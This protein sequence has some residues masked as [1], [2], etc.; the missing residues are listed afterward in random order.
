MNNNENSIE[1][2]AELVK[3]IDFAMMT[4][5]DESGH[6]HSRP[7]S[8]QQ[9]DKETSCFW[10]FTKD[11]FPKA[12]EIDA[13]PHVNLSYSD[14]AHNRY[15]SV[16]GHAEIIHDKNKMKELWNPLLRAWFPLGLEEPHIC[17]IR[18]PVEKAEYWD[19]PSSKMIQLAGFIKAVL[20]GKP[21]EYAGENKKI[22]IRN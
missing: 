18:I 14:P 1:K 21:L 8:T 16:S 6:L 22:N 5:F 4:T 12:K 9:F 11:D 2:L 19:S 3:G 13:D 7:M 15:V 17:L 20:T 10:F